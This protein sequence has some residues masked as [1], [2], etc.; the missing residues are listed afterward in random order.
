M[1]D[2]WLALRRVGE[3]VGFEGQ[4]LSEYLTTVRPIHDQALEDRKG[5]ETERDLRDEYFEFLNENVLSAEPVVNHLRHYQV[6]QEI[7]RLFETGSVPIKDTFRSQSVIDYELDEIVDF[8]MLLKLLERYQER[9]ESGVEP[10]ENL[11]SLVYL[12]NYQLSESESYSATEDHG[13]GMLEKTGYRYTFERRDDYVWSDSLQRDL[14]RLVAWQLLDRELI[15]EPKPE[16]DRTYSISLG[17]AATLFLTRFE[18]RLDSF[19]SLLLNE[20]EMRQDDVI[21]DFATSSKVGISSHLDSLDRFRNCSDGQIVLN[22]RA[23]KFTSDQDQRGIKI[24]V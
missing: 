4:E 5:S 6:D 1:T 22:G 13:F 8:V 2:R 19:D 7:V 11:H 21:D 23:K 16:W 18:K 9:A 3:W 15:D 10:L 12:I 14:D 17:Q 24:N 20:W